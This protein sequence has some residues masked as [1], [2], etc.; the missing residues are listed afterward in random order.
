[1]AGCLQAVDGEV[2]GG[3]TVRVIVTGSRTWNRPSLV[4]EILTEVHKNQ[5]PDTLTVTEGGC[6]TGADW[7]AR[8]WV[9]SRL[10]ASIETVVGVTHPADW[11]RLGKYAGRARNAHM[12]NLG[13]DLC[14][15]FM[16]PCKD[17]FCPR[18]GLHGTHGTEDMI[19][20]AEDRMIP[21]RIFGEYS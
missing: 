10:D 8:S 9:Q 17:T 11:K 18:Q 12:A 6:P 1:M 21:V 5:L 19:R 14:L 7:F 4:Y 13:A 16:M 15:A 20:K 2:P 3:D